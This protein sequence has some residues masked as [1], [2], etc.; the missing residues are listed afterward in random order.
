MDNIQG[1]IIRAIQNDKLVHLAQEVAHITGGQA[2]IVGDWIW[3]RFSEKPS[4][5]CRTYLKDMGFHWNSK[6]MIWQYAGSQKRVS[7]PAS[8]DY[9]RMKYGVVEVQ[10]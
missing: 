9:L 2:E 10:S 4:E 3:L 1:T 7:S 6:R 8:S 5:D